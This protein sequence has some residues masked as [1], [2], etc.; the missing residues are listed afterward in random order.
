[1]SGC[2]PRALEDSV[3]PRR[4]S[5]VVVRP[6]NFT[7]RGRSKN[8]Q[9]RRDPEFDAQ[10]PRPF[11]YRFRLCARGQPVR[12]SARPAPVAAFCRSCASAKRPG[13]GCIGQ[14][15]FAPKIPRVH[16]RLCEGVL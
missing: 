11:V 3:R 6:L 15:R 5:G 8:L 9:G 4:L 7:V 2:A 12:P 13:R 14:F 10:R 1:M 16:S